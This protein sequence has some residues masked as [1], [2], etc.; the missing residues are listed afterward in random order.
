MKQILFLLLAVAAG[1]S[2]KAQAED[3]PR[4]QETARSFMRVGD[5]N[6][7]I[8][9]LSKALLKD[10]DNLE[11][12]KDLV[13]AYT[14]DRNFSKAL[15]VVKPLL[16]RNDAD[17]QV[18]Q[19]G[20]NVYKALAETK[21]AEKM[22]KKALKKFPR[23]GPLYSEYGELLWEKKDYEAIQLWE[24]GIEVDPS[25]PGTIT[26]QLPIIISQRTKYGALSTVRS[27]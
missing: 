5:W 25:Y 19:L 26:T 14:Y 4:P 7:A 23:S 11:L 8:L 15:E 17:V 18:Y 20:G 3:P 13:L 12:S 1:F 22:Y 16:E 24:K 10:P 2:V 9:V 6:N 21:D 27:L